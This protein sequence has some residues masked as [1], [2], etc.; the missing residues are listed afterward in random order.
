M[1]EEEGDER[2]VEDRARGDDFAIEPGPAAS[3]R[4]T[5]RRHP[6]TGRPTRPARSPAAS[7][8]VE[9]GLT[10]GSTRSRVRP[11][12]R[13]RNGSPCRSPPHGPG[14]ANGAGRGTVDRGEKRRERASNDGR[15]DELAKSSRGPV[16][17][18]RVRAGAA[19]IVTSRI[20]PKT[21]A[22]EGFTKAHARR[23]GQRHS[24][25]APSPARPGHERRRRAR[26]C[27]RM[28]GPCRGPSRRA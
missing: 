8:R 27:R 10:P 26:G 6:R 13:S 17:M 19:K 25:D 24:T 9:P 5:R 3:V 18:L 22:I 14:R 20:S 16:P 28:S 15:R 23:Q 1:G 11:R 12:R 4:E 2:G 21:D 7:R